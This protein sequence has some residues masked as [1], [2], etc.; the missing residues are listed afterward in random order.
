M[1]DNT[2]PYY[3]EDYESIQLSDT[4]YQIT[5]E[6]LRNN[7]STFTTRLLGL[8]N[9]KGQY[10]SI[11][12]LQPNELRRLCFNKLYICGVQRSS[13]TKQELMNVIVGRKL[14]YD[15]LKSN[16]DGEDPFL[17]K[18]YLCPD[19]NLGAEFI[20]PVSYAGT[21]EKYLLEKFLY[22]ERNTAGQVLGMNK[23]QREKMIKIILFKIR[24]GSFPATD[25]EVKQAG[26]NQNFKS[27]LYNA[28]R[29]FI[30]EKTTLVIQPRIMSKKE[31]VMWSSI[32]YQFEISNKVQQ[33]VQQGQEDLTRFTR[34]FREAVADIGSNDIPFDH[35]NEWLV[36][37][38]N[39]Y[40]KR[41]RNE[42]LGV[43]RT[44]ILTALGV[45]LERESLSVQ[46][47]KAR[48]D[49]FLDQYTVYK[50][51]CEDMGI[52]PNLPWFM[53]CV[54]EHAHL[55]PLARYT[56]D[57]MKRVAKAN[58]EKW[59]DIMDDIPAS[60]LP[61]SEV[62][63]HAYDVFTKAGFDFDPPPRRNRED[64]LEWKR[65]YAFDKMKDKDDI[66]MFQPNQLDMPMDGSN[67]KRPDNILINGH[68][69]RSES[70]E[71]D[72]ANAV[73]SYIV[74]EADEENGHIKYGVI[75][76]KR[77]ETI[78]INKGFA[79][80]AYAMFIVRTNTRFDREPNENQMAKEKQVLEAIHTALEEGEVVEGSAYWIGVDFIPE[81]PHAKGSMGRQIPI[82]PNGLVAKTAE[83]EDEYYLPLYTSVMLVS[84]KDTTPFI[85][86]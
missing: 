29:V 23:A 84:S 3:N 10:Q 21:R 39:Y 53:S 44:E 8:N 13:C 59:K 66:P 48:V 1:D 80:G 70:G 56:Y 51:A 2:F 77:W 75:K 5:P 60:P 67:N 45:N 22:P 61:L 68:K 30:G 52:E 33:K 81:H 9:E 4:E 42:E 7:S 78:V 31:Y 50:T 65:N 11:K 73:N 14:S 47:Q 12:D 74:H 49:D 86:E 85:L 72:L 19:N 71:L 36:T 54:N 24:T 16:P 17:L 40:V 6:T 25:Q 41:H 15:S 83:S 69:A 37:K 82:L 26:V 55:K 18:I 20:P 43:K 34:E 38:L 28:Y 63:Q 35:S 32:G 46:R 62:D 79:M 64:R 58:P 57:L 27:E 76:Q